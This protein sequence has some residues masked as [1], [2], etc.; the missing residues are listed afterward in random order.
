MNRLPQLE[1]PAPLTREQRRPIVEKIRLMGESLA[2]FDK[3]MREHLE[4]GRL[5]QDQVAE[6]DRDFMQSVRDRRDALHKQLGQI[7]P[8]EY[9]YFANGSWPTLATAQDL[10][11][12]T[13]RQLVS[14]H[15]D[16]QA[17]RLKPSNN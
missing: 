2:T 3:Q 14:D 1:T 7:T 15:R 11:V 6:L 12:E 13:K 17:A 16:R 4:S 8:E 5:N 10:D 9:W